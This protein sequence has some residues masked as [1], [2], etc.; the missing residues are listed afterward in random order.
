MDTTNGVGE[1]ADLGGINAV[2]I[3]KTYPFV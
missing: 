1:L 3:A 2:L